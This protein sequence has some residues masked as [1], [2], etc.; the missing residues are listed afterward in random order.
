VEGATPCFLALVRHRA[1]E[2]VHAKVHHFPSV[3]GV[4]PSTVIPGGKA[5]ERFFA[6]MVDECVSV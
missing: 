6:L 4:A 2:M 5:I 3:F 1:G